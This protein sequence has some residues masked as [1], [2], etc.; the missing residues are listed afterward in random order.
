MAATGGTLLAAP[1][2]HAWYGD[3][4]LKSVS[5]N[6]GK[7]IVVGTKTPV[8][9]P[10]TAQLQNSS[11]G[12]TT[13]DAMLGVGD[14]YS[15]F[16]LDGPAGQNMTCEKTTSTVSTCTG[17]ATVHPTQLINSATAPAWLRISG[18][19][20]DGGQYLL[21]SKYP[22]YADL[23]GATVPVL[24]QTTLTVKAGPK[25][26][27]K[28][29]TLTIT[30]QLSRPD[31][32]LLNSDGL[33][34]ASAGYANQPVKLQFMKAGA[35]SYSTVKTVTSDTSGK[36]RTTVTATT[37]GTWRWAFS[38][39]STSS[40]SVST[41]DGV[42][43]LKVSKLT[44]TA[45]PK[46][47]RKG[48]KLTVTGRLTRATSDAATTFAGY[49]NQP[50][51][52]QFRKYGSNTYSTIKTVRTDSAG[53]L[54]TTTAA[55]AAGYWRWSYAGSATVASVTTAGTYVKLK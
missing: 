50:V 41:G 19:A 7:P 1:P 20:Y 42:T 46:P 43:L 24:K 36:L 12:I 15:F 25:P 55:N 14:G 26:V 21:N 44:V 45:A 31:W 39:N 11:G 22:E 48:G 16:F 3:T 2:A 23:P 5:I 17:T 6:G 37:S 9:V 53:R 32:N 4:T 29:G 47:V 18:Y 51:K 8:P 13:I 27:R 49:A 30:G 40:A 54:K 33:S 38:Q 10:I 35:T 34:T 52:L 28:G